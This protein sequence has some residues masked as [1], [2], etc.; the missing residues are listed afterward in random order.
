MVTGV[1]MNEKLGGELLIAS[2]RPWCEVWI[3]YNTT[4]VMSPIQYI[5]S[6]V[7]SDGDS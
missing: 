1:D 4:S 5:P 2:S 6:G 7:A 3:E